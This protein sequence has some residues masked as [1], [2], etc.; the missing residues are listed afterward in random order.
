MFAERLGDQEG[1][2]DP[3]A[4][5]QPFG[6][7]GDEDRRHRRDREDVLHRIDA[8][9]SVR[10]LDIGEDEAG[11][12]FLKRREDR[13]SVVEGKGVSVRVDLGGRRIIKKKKKKMKTEQD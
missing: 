8:R 7:G 4:G 6:K 11:G 12:G 1:R 5:E 13:K 10:K 2:L 3:P 9:R